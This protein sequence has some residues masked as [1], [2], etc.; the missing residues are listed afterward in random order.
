M[1]LDLSPVDLTKTADFA[2]RIAENA[3]ANGQ[4]VAMECDNRCFTWSAF[5][6]HTCRVANGLAECGCRPGDRVAI[7]ASNSIEYF[8]CFMGIVSGGMS[9]VTIPTMVDAEAIGTMLNDSE[10]KV[11]FA[12]GPEVE[13]AASAIEHADHLF[14]NGRIAYDFAAAGWEDYG[15]WLETAPETP[16][17]ASVSPDAEFNIVYSSGT[18]GRPKGIV[19]SHATR[20][21]MAQG[22][23]NLGFD[24]QAVTML[25]SPLY[26]NLSIPACLGTLW[27]GGMSLVMSKFDAPRYLE[28]AESRKATHFFLVP[29]VAERLLNDPAFDRTNLSATR[30]KYIGGS[31][32]RLELKRALWE[33]WPG[34][35]LEIYGMTEGAPVTCFHPD[36]H[37][38]KIGSVGRPAAGC[39]ICIVDDEDNELPIGETGEI[40]GRSGSMMLGYNNLPEETERLIW[41]D[42]EGREF[43]RSGDIGRFDDDGF[44]YIQDRKKDMIISGGL[45]IYAADLEPVIARHLD[46][47]EVA[48]IAIPSDRWGETPL[49]LVV[50]KSGAQATE[51]EILDW[52]SSRLGKYQRLARVE[53][54]EELPRNPMGKIL[55]RELREPYWQGQ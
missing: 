26:T 32:L 34:P 23:E 51:E 11:L 3:A 35:L 30:L 25:F 31:L 49:A 12:S 1:R 38:D 20:A 9:A 36:Q 54:R 19:H 16:P 22:F 37:L 5:Y 17:A 46:V 14:E 39:E 18:T 21:S 24:Q 4:G 28:L 47:A 41:R 45:N 15:A 33:R 6:S 40:A 44:L 52:S 43:F 27:G 10:A 8:S 50:L 55:K 48:V 42:P 29:S 53:F 7:L 2:S 13:R